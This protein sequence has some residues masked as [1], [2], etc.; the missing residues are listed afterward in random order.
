MEFQDIATQSMKKFDDLQCKC[1]PSRS[2]PEKKSVR[3]T[4]TEPEDVERS[5][6]TIKYL[7]KFTN[8]SS[9]LSYI[10]LNKLAANDT[11]EAS[12]CPICNSSG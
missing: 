10:F 12:I 9:S 2:M 3:R 5:E 7:K 8:H 11:N 6:A 1:G 4:I